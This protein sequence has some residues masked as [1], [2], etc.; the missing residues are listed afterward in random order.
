MGNDKGG[1]IDCFTDD[2]TVPLGHRFGAT[3]FL[4]VIIIH[5]LFLLMLLSISV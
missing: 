1:N 4:S 3:Y 5:I 2:Q